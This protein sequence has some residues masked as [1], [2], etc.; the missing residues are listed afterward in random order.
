MDAPGQAEAQGRVVAAQALGTLVG[1]TDVDAPAHG[2]AIPAWPPAA[3]C[4]SVASA[5]TTED[6][7]EPPGARIYV[8][9]ADAQGESRPTCRSAIQKR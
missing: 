7:W 4:C 5:Q 8:S 2:T 9:P 6:R 1:G 3:A